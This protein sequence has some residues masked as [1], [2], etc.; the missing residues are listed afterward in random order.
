MQ[1]RPTLAP[2]S[3]DSA[4]L[5]DPVAKQQAVDAPLPSVSPPQQAPKTYGRLKV[6]AA[7][8]KDF[9]AEPPTL[10]EKKTFAGTAPKRMIFIGDIHGSAKELNLLLCKLKFKKGEDQV[11][12]VGDLVSK[13]PE[14][15]AVI[16]RARQ[17]SAWCTRGNHDD[18]VIRWRE[19][20]DGPGK[21]LSQSELK[22]LEKSKG[23]PYDD[24]KTSGDHYQIARDMSPDDITWMK[25]FPTIMSLPSPFSEWV[26]V[27]G[28]LDPSK[29]LL[30]QSAEAVMVTR[31]IASGGPTS[32]RTEGQ[33]WFELWADKVKGLNNGNSTGGNDVDFNEIH[34]N[35][36]IYGHDAGR[37]LQLHPLTK[38]LDSRCV[39]GGQLTAFILP[40][41]KIVSV[42][43]PNYDGGNAGKDGRRRRR[44]AIPSAK[45]EPM[46]T[47]EQ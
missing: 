30:K 5:T 40:G 23:L 7:E 35:K 19:F 2:D 4:H 26:V 8:V 41:E 46:Y 29:P 14:S 13:G 18:R 37:N 22:D 6:R 33:A 32:S 21:A 3:V 47:V 36:I 9:R 16:R 25:A 28:G 17:I 31:N 34:F 11:V 10:F 20:L 12:L 24:F 44:G 27:H 38:G 39:Y 43:C 15:V 42:T 45:A 1:A